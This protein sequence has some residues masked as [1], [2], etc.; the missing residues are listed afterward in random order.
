MLRPVGV[1]AVCGYAIVVFRQAWQ[2]QISW[3]RAI[4]T[5]AAGW[6]PAALATLA[7]VAYEAHTAALVGVHDNATYLH[8]FKVADE[9]LLAQL[10]EGVRVRGSEMGRLLVPG[11]FKAY[12]PPFRWWNINM[13]VY[14]P[15]VCGLAWAW[16]N[17]SRDKRS[18]LLLMFPCYLALYIVYPSDQGA[19]YLLPLLPVLV[20]CLW[21]L[22][23]Q[24]PRHR[25]ALLSALV[26]SHLIVTVAYS[27]AFDEAAGADQRAVG[28][29]RRTGR[30]IA[31]RSPP[32][33]FLEAAH[34]RARVGDGRGRSPH[35]GGAR[36]GRSG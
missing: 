4:G 20:V 31:R 23:C 25:V 21:W 10:I 8:E 32:R 27:A 6:Q 26:A 7:L 36:R 5:H 28:R 9:S 34:W 15:L 30:R 2:G 3:Q 16:W 19:R 35:Q 17:V 24:M 12:A 29:C 13:A 22:V 33:S 1:M 11:M 18:A 14:V